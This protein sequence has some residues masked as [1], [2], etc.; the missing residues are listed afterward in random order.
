MAR[1]GVKPREMEIEVAWPATAVDRAV[2][3]IAR[4]A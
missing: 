4:M 2:L 3:V 1:D